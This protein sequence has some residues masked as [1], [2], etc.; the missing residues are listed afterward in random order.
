[1]YGSGTT[2]L[3]ISNEDLNDMIKILKALEDSD[4]LLK[5]ITETLKSDVRKGGFLNTVVPM[6][7]GTLGSSLLNNLTGERLYRT[8]YGI[9]K[10]IYRTGY[11]L[12]KSSNA[13]TSFNKV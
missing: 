12:K 9:G 1:M 8:G 2:T 13:T 7:I 4:V 11:G 3:I 5:G 6:L 10:G